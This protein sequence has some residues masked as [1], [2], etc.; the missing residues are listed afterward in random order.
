M[1]KFNI[2]SEFFDRIGFS[3]YLFKDM[4]KSDF[5]TWISMGKDIL[6]TS[7]YKS[8]L[9]DTKDILIT[10][11]YYEWISVVDNELNTLN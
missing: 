8:V 4:S 1:Q 9:I 2:D 5:I 11:E 7:Q 3:E 6:D 10:L